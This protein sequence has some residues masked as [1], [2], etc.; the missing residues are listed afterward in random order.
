MKNKIILISHDFAVAGAEISL[1]Q[2]AKILNV[3]NEIE[4]YSL[5]SG[6]L[7]DEYNKIGI[8]CTIINKALNLYDY[9]L[10]FFDA[11]LVIVNTVIPSIFVDIFERY[12]IPYIW[13]IREGSNIPEY[14]N[15]SYKLKE[16]IC[17]SKNIYATSEYAKNYIDKNFNQ[18]VKVLHN[19]VPDLFK[20][21]KFIHKKILKEKLS[22]SI[23]GYIDK[24][25]AQDICIKAFNDLPQNLKDKCQLNIIGNI[26]NI[27]NSYLKDYY[28]V[29]K[30]KKMFNWT[31]LLTDEIKQK[32]F[33]ET[34]VFIVPSLDESCSRIVLEAMMLGKPVIISKNVGA[35]Y[36]ITTETGWI[37][38]TGDIKSLTDC[39]ASII[40]NPEQLIKM[41]IKT[42]EMYLKTS[43]EEI[44]KENLFK[45]INF[46]LSKEKNFKLFK[47]IKKMGIII[48]IKTKCLKKI[49]SIENHQSKNKKWYKVVTI[50]GIKFS[51]RN[52]HKEQ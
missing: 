48:K 2:I 1:L 32:Y 43:T 34:D 12:K 26:K 49:F 40:R 20:D 44:Y 30:N 10:N 13:L 38:E 29:T 33:Q 42:R 3:K 46:H 23:V 50:L 31:G 45:I 37:V 18:N 27:N 14:Y 5:D 41:Q 8:K 19:Y 47:T 25:K 4:V 17:K 51:F 9:I 39:V 35:K 6:P 11:K 7:I 15:K 36:M 52:K 16:T 22:F 21:K 24:R 28:E